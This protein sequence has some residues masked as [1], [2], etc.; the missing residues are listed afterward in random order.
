MYIPSLLGVCPAPCP[1]SH[2]R[3]GPRTPQ[4]VQPEESE[5]RMG[6]GFCVRCP[7]LPKK[8]NSLA[9]TRFSEYFLNFYVL[10]IKYAFFITRKHWGPFL[11]LPFRVLF[12]LP[13]GIRD[14]MLS[15][16]AEGLECR[17]KQP[18]SPRFWWLC[19]I[20]LSSCEID[21]RCSKMSSMW[22]ES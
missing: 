8:T 3:D 1:I 13:S 6:C 19:V 21:D 18:L 12:S 15:L 20:G 22:A 11:S 14:G 10:Y 2:Q 5:E 9:V 17:R 4:V 7:S 16:L